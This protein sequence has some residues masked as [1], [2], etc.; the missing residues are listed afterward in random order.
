MSPLYHFC[1]SNFLITLRTTSE[2][3]SVRKFVPNTLVQSV[4]RNQIRSYTAAAAAPITAKTTKDLK[5][6]KIVKKLPRTSRDLH[7]INSDKYVK[8]RTNVWKLKRRRGNDERR[9]SLERDIGG[10]VCF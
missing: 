7:R 1:Y 2:M 6:Y 8:Y 5:F 4:M 9:P 3:Q 10:S